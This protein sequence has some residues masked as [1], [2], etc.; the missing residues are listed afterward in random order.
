[1]L[2]EEHFFLTSLR[3]EICGRKSTQA[4]LEAVSIYINS[5][6]FAA[7]LQQVASNLEELTDIFCAVRQGV[8]PDFF[9]NNFRPWIQGADQGAKSPPWQ[10]EGTNLILQPSG[11]SAGQS[12]MMQSFDAFLGIQHPHNAHSPESGCAYINSALNPHQDSRPAPSSTQ[13][14]LSHATAPECPVMSKRRKATVV[15]EHDDALDTSFNARMRAYMPK[16]HQE[17]LLWLARHTPF[18]QEPSL[19]HRRT[20]CPVEVKVAYNA[21]VSAME[22]W[23]NAHIQIVTRYVILPARRKQCFEARTQFNRQ[24]KINRAHCSQA[25]PQIVKQV[26]RGTGGT[27]LVPLLKVYRENTKKAIMQGQSHTIGANA[28]TAH[29]WSD[30]KLTRQSWCPSHTDTMWLFS[31][32]PNT[33]RAIPS[34]FLPSLRSVWT[35]VLALLLL[36]VSLATPC[37]DPSQMDR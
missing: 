20:A 18:R 31:L 9:Y 23:R 26:V 24:A 5:T 6:E 19:I 2:Q 27:S 28:Q 21:A 15:R 25:E 10:C 16:E 13:A 8:E 32:L 37:L 12:A 3:M 1:M 34:S 14:C 22:R 35:V 11:P 36:D 7:S 30:E 33:C 4:M 17:Y 29:N